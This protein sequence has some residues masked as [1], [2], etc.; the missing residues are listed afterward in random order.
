MNQPSWNQVIRELPMREIARYV[1]GFAIIPTKG[2]VLIRKNRPEWQAGKLN[3][4]GGKIEPGE[5]PEAAMAREFLEETGF[6]TMQSDWRICGQCIGSN[7]T[8]DVFVAVLP[9]DA[10]VKTMTDEEIVLR[11]AYYLSGEDVLPHVQAMYYC[12]L[13]RIGKDN[14]APYFTFHY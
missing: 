8:I 7:F 13:M 14:A 2:I 4:V 1:L 11:G 3:G 6:N 12:C 5:L 9:D 10:V